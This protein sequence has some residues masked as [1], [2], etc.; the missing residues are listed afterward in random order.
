MKLDDSIHRVE[1]F[2]LEVQQEALLKWLHLKW[3]ITLTMEVQLS[4]K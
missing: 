4:Q 3:P 1:V 2:Q